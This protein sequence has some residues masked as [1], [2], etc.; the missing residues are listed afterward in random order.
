[1]ISHDIGF[2]APPQVLLWRRKRS[3][4][5]QLVVPVQVILHFSARCIFGACSGHTFVCVLKEGG[6]PHQTSSCGLQSGLQPDWVC[7]TYWTYTFLSF[8]SVFIWLFQSELEQSTNLLCWHLNQQKIIGI[9]FWNLVI[10]VSFFD[11]VAIIEKLKRGL[12]RAKWVM[13]SEN[14]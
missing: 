4:W 12:F 2:V 3:L 10:V 11:V 8:H 14:I 1:M 9:F 5:C 7:S 13:K 6:N